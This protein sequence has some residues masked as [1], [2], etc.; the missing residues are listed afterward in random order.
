MR[1]AQVVPSGA[2]ADGDWK[3]DESDV[4]RQRLGCL[5]GGGPTTDGPPA[6]MI[7]ARADFLSTWSVV[8]SSKKPWF[9]RIFFH[10]ATPFALAAKLD[11][12]APSGD[13]GDRAREFRP[14][15]G[16]MFLSLSCP[17]ANYF[18]QST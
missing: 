10:S 3:A 15:F 11:A 4:A 16:P 5:F 12:G 14:I 6:W 18:I 7:R 1:N 2:M 17:R 8:G 9:R 13:F